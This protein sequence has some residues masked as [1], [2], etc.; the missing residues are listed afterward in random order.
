MDI[1]SFSF[2]LLGGGAV[3]ETLFVFNLEGDLLPIT[4]SR[5]ALFAAKQK[6][7]SNGIM[8]VLD[9]ILLS[10]VRLRLALFAGE[11][12]IKRNS[13]S[14]WTKHGCQFHAQ[15]CLVHGGR[16]T[17]KGVIVSCGAVLEFCELLS[18]AHSVCS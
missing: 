11:K 13:C 4:C 8:F 3:N 12:Y 6:P 15:I 5:F 10:A 18:C 17:S 2:G 14:V 16:G 7:S 1:C 9:D